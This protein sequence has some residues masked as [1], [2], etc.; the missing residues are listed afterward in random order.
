MNKKLI[1]TA[2]RIASTSSVAYVVLQILDVYTTYLITPNLHRE[3]N[4]LV[5]RFDL[6]WGYVV[7]SALVS[8]LIMIAGQFWAWKNLFELFP[9]REKAYKSFYR[10]LFFAET[11]LSENYGKYEIRGALS[12]IVIII[13]FGLIASKLLVVIWNALLLFFSIAVSSLTY[14]MLIKNF[15]SGLFGVF[16]FFVFPYLLHKKISMK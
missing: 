7:I 8:S 15:L 16:M 5:A 13:L 1:K 4:I 10:H 6:G 11:S 2:H 14:F 9:T 3:A 12:S